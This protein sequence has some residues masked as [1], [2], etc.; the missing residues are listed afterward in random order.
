MPAANLLLAVTWYLALYTSVEPAASVA[1]AQA[2][3]CGATGLTGGTYIRYARYGDDLYLAAEIPPQQD[4]RRLSLSH[5][6]RHLS[7]PLAKPLSTGADSEESS[8][9][10]SP[11]SA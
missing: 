5:F 2:S 3:Q 4:L 1:L 6:R 8:L 10:T 9:S 7:L 11:Y